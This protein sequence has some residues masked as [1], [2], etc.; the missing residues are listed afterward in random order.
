MLWNFTDYGFYY[1]FD[2]LCFL[3]TS[4][5]F[6][7]STF[8]KRLSLPSWKKQKGMRKSDLNGLK[9]HA[10]RIKKSREDASLQGGGGGRE[11]RYKFVKVN[12]KIQIYRIIT[13]NLKTREQD[14]IRN[15]KANCLLL[16]WLQNSYE[17]IGERL[18]RN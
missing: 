16:W 9:G 17:Q 15:E 6:F 3:H 12:S 4:C 8:L 5:F 14:I 18:R 1:F 13:K 2:I 10:V 11:E 7:F